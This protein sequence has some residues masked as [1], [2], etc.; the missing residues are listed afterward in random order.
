MFCPQTN[1]TRGDMAVFLEDARHPTAT[2]LPAAIGVFA[3]V[4]IAFPLA[5]WIEVFYNDGIT[6]GCGTNPLRYCPDS[7]VSRAEMAVFILKAKKPP[8][9]APPNCDP[10]HPM[11]ADVPCP[12][13]F[14]VNWIE[15]FA[16]EC[17]TAGCG[18]GNFCPTG[19]VTREQMGIFLWNAFVTSSPCTASCS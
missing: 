3:D 10:Q 12:S 16:R 8:G 5:C 7:S 14:A 19:T 1:V 15:E 13:G 4:P 6:A 9:Y 18:G 11:F 17:I 2:S